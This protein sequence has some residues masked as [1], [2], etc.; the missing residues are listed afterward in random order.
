[1]DWSVLGSAFGLVFLAE[2][3][4]KTQLAIMTQTC[5]YRCGW[6]VFLGGSLALT[7][8]TA[9]GVAAGQAIARF[10]PPT[11]VRILAAGAFLVM[12]VLLWWEAA[13][14][15]PFED[16]ETASCTPAEGRTWRW[17]A[18]STTFALLFVAELGDKTQLAVLSLTA[19]QSAAWLVF[20]GGTLALISVTALG[21]LGGQQ[22]CRLLP[23]RR[24]LRLSAGAFVIIGV[25]MTL[26]IL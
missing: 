17:K 13:Q 9:L 20:L 16:G 7:L 22:I 10:V 11:L 26:G 18:F 19:Q 23:E 8:V 24:L 1:M 3:G 14:H 5:R 2:L 6:A 4:D 12:G 21:V 15:A 25:L